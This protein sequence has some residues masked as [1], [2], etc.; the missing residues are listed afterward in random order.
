MKMESSK[1]KKILMTSKNEDGK[2]NENDNVE[3]NENDIAENNENEDTEFNENDN[4]ELVKRKESKEI[5]CQLNKTR[6]W[7]WKYF[8]V[9]FLN[10]IC[11]SFFY[12]CNVF[13]LKRFLFTWKWVFMYTLPQFCP[14]FHL[15]VRFCLSFFTIAVLI[16]YVYK[17]HI[18]AIL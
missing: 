1:D 16:L 3:N 6:G 17:V 11:I 2:L 12:S 5:N 8:I 10:Q 4:V 13:F 9:I 14:P 7:L 15:A 18:H